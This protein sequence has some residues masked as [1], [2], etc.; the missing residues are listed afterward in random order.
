MRAEASL[1]LAKSGRHARS[2]IG[3]PETAKART[4]QLACAATQRPLSGHSTAIQRPFNGHSGRYFSSLF[5]RFFIA[6]KN[7]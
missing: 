1:D 5:H 3:E 6:M 4:V 7:R 2:G